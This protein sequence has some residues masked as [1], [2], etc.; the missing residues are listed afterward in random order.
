MAHG[1][2]PDVRDQHDGATATRAAPD[3]AARTVVAATS[4][5]ALC[6]F[7][8][9]GRGSAGGCA[10][11]YTSD[12][13]FTDSRGN[14][15]ATVPQCV[16]IEYGPLPVVML[17]LLAIMAAA[18]FWIRHR[19]ARDRPTG[20]VAKTAV[21]VLAVLLALPVAAQVAYQPIGAIQEW[22]ETGV[23]PQ[24]PA[25]AGATVTYSEM[26]PPPDLP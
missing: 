12:G 13:G 7:L 24:P 19:R 4:I 16:Q 5:A 10:G 20:P 25:L 11:G 14:P 6:Y 21:P 8:F 22:R 2:D 18:L 9:T 26:P 17:L 23:L 1:Q 15:T 3:P